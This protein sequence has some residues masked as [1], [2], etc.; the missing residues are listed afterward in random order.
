MNEEKKQPIVNKEGTAAAGGNVSAM[1]QK[2]GAGRGSSGFRPRGKGFGPRRGAK[3]VEKKDEYEQ[4]ILDIARVTRVMAGGK[5]M[6]FRACVAIGDGKGKVAVGLGKGIDVTLAVN[7]AVNRAKREIIDVP[8]IKE[9][10]PHEVYYKYCAA[11]ILFKP[12][13]AGRGVK[14]G[15]IVRSILELAGVKNITSKVLGSGNKVANA[16][17]TIEALK[18]LKRVEQPSAPKA[19]VVKEDKVAKVEDDKKAE[20]ENKEEVKKEAK[21][22]N[23]KK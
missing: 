2:Q 10:I 13:S 5:R 14:A 8:I 9:T 6:R 20:A 16:H 23:K 15:G 19:E 12:A 22:I 21:K 11:K 7:K 4:R 1:E 18:R 3:P 17:C